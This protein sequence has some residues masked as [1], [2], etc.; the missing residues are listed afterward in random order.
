M[1]MRSRLV[2][3]YF[4][5]NKLLE[6]NGFAVE[7]ETS[8]ASMPFNVKPAR[9]KNL[10]LFSDVIE[11]RTRMMQ[12]WCFRFFG[13]L[14]W[15]AV[16]AAVANGGTSKTRPAQL[17]FETQVMERG[18]DFGEVSFGER[19][20]KDVSVTNTGDLVAVF[21][22][23]K[24]TGSGFSISDKPPAVI[25][26]GQAGKLGIAFVPVGSG[27]HRGVLTLSYVTSVNDGAIST[28]PIEVELDLLGVGP[29]GGVDVPSVVL[30]GR[31]GLESGETSDVL[32]RNNG[33]A[34]VSVSV[35]IQEDSHKVFSVVRGATLDIPVEKHRTVV[36]R[37]VPREKL[38][39]VAELI[40]TSRTEAGEQ[41]TTGV[42][43]LQCTG[44]T[45]NVQVE[46]TRLD[47]GAQEVGAFGGAKQF[48]LSNPDDGFTLPAI[49]SLQPATSLGSD[50]SLSPSACVHPEQCVLGV[51]ATRSMLVGFRPTARHDRA[52]EWK[53][54]TGGALGVTFLGFGIG[55]ELFLEPAEIQFGDVFV[56]D[57]SNRTVSIGNRGELSLQVER[58]EIIGRDSQDFVFER[59]LR[60]PITLPAQT[61][62]DIG[63]LCKPRNHGEKLATVR[64]ISDDPVEKTEEV[65]LRCSGRAAALR[66]EP[67]H[68]EFPKTPLC[69]R[70]KPVALRIY[71]DGNEPL[72]VSTSASSSQYT[73]SAASLQ[74]APGSQVSLDVGFRPITSV[75]R[76]EGALTINSNDPL[77]Q[78]VVSLS[79]QVLFGEMSISPT[80]VDF[81]NLAVG[82]KVLSAPVVISNEE[83]ATRDFRV[84]SVT[85]SD[86]DNFSIEKI[87]HP[88]ATP[89]PSDNDMFSLQPGQS[90]RFSVAAQL[91][92]VGDIGRAATKRVQAKIVTDIPM[93]CGL[94]QAFVDVMATGVESDIVH[95]GSIVFGSHDVDEPKAT[96]KWSVTKLSDADVIVTGI[97]IVGRVG[98][99][100]QIEKMPS[101]PFSLKTGEPLEVEVSYDPESEATDSAL[102]KI[103]VVGDLEAQSIVADL[104][105][106]GIDRTIEVNPSSIE[107]GVTFRNPEQP[108]VRNVE[109]RNTGTAPLHISEFVVEGDFSGA[110]RL[111]TNGPLT[112]E[113]ETARSVEIA[114]DPSEGG[115][116]NARL[117][118]VHD[119]DDT[120]ESQTTILLGGDSKVPTIS[121]SLGS[122][123]HLGQTGV[124]VPVSIDSVHVQPLQIVNKES[125]NFTVRELRLVDKDGEPIISGPF[126]VREFTPGEILTGN[127]SLAANVEFLPTEPG[128]FEAT[129]EVYVVGDEARVAA[130]EIS[131][132]AS[133]IAVRG[134]GCSA[135][136]EE[137]MIGMIGMLLLLG[138]RRRMRYWVVIAGLFLTLWVPRVAEAQPTRNIDIRTFHPDPGVEANMFSVES[139][140]VGAS[141][142]WSV[143]VFLNHAVNPL[144]VQSGEM[145]EV[146]VSGR[147]G[148]DIAF[149]Y[150]FGGRF[151]AGAIIPM[152]LQSGDTAMFSGLEANDGA[153][154]G[155][156]A[157]HGKIRVLTLGAFSVGTSAAVT[158]PTASNEEFAGSES[159]TLHTRMMLG[160]DR[161]PIYVAAN[162]GFRLRGEGVLGNIE[163]GNELTYGLALSYE[164][165]RSIAIVAETFGSYAV[166]VAEVDAVSPLE[167]VLGTRL[168]LGSRAA[169]AMGV[170]RGIRSGIGAPDFRGFL[171]LSFAPSGRRKGQAK[172]EREVIKAE[173]RKSSSCPA[174]MVRG[175]QGVCITVNDSDMDGVPDTLDLCPTQKEDKDSFQDDDGCPELDN[176]E[177]GLVDEKDQCRNEKEDLDGFEDGDGCS[178]PDNDSDGILDVADKCPEQPETI[179]GNQDA[180]GCPDDGDALVVVLPDRI[181][182]FE[183]VYFTKSTAE[184]AK[185]SENILGQIAATLQANRDFV[186]VRIAAHVHSQGDSDMENS[187]NR[188]E[189][190]RQWLVRWG[191]AKERLEV[192][193]YGSSKP[194]V[195]PSH[196][197][198]RKLNNRV[199]FLI[200]E[201]RVK[202]GRKGS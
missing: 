27:E 101:V 118:I 111:G 201:K 198:S 132:E 24:V 25:R 57:S 78:H 164:A 158:L 107:F 32:V 95:D 109:I 134:G 196:K 82:K 145:E 102:L 80:E 179:N 154:L 100:F 123:I 28:G 126:Q 77:G 122:S 181:E 129:L 175:D 19:S 157:L 4:F 112:I 31:V 185:S 140:K 202:K 83:S 97:D 54:S 155:D 37:C 88:D 195:P 200:L 62:L 55:S 22:T 71:N 178:D 45:Q 131:G 2:K 10:E 33:G 20:V 47:F 186:R 159:A 43:K 190:V 87:V 153:V 105:G 89:T 56:L 148:A 49:I 191:V 139:P 66:I 182:A 70:A 184:I 183:P 46:P 91:Q 125:R 68:I 151:E 39:Y 152:V 42:T 180:D 161:P 136:G 193:G 110:F 116:I 44:A 104:I 76:I 160:Y 15:L 16:S 84:L 173:K 18:L 67:T 117:R 115:R 130:L 114:F 34:S 7:E 119:D 52:V 96:R 11:F 162:T 85:I 189:A 29:R 60:L 17:E 124:G 197:D 73:V 61:S 51:G 168:F 99:P 137:G 163:Q 3:R 75:G 106:S 30:F 98:T 90:A 86:T 192:R 13:L 135:N 21:V 166:Q 58:I 170:G 150:A 199:E 59:D 94:P 103:S 38:V 81:G 188:A 141:G 142:T 108:I 1:G 143:G 133:E 64:V 176:D 128:F 194:L 171:M 187:Q 149:S 48:T 40:V 127:G 172:V 147:T 144:K 50:F 69:E 92:S 79:G 169:I 5:P 65:G 9:S 23:A 53:V 12:R 74:I 121:L 36:V 165:T 8:C 174:G 26:G 156:I 41:L 138:W 113:P 14:G 35:D 63:V 167:A 6:Y 177:D 120:G 93:D 72:R 146:P